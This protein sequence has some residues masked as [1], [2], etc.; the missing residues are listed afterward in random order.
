VI[1]YKVSYVVIGGE[2][3]G[4]IANEVERPRVGGRVRIGR[5]MFEIAEIH[6]V[7]PPREDFVFLHATVRPVEVAEHP[8]E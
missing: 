6:E 8:A 1:T 5:A 4:A 7:L 2:H 3:P